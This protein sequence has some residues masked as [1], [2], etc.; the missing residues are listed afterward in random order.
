MTKVRVRFGI[1]LS[2][3]IS[4]VGIVVSYVTQDSY[5]KILGSVEVL[6]QLLTAAGMGEA[7]SRLVFERS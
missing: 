2:W 5:D 6:K 7:A 3:P 1:R 4:N